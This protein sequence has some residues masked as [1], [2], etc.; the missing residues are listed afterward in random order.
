MATTTNTNVDAALR[1]L[2]LVCSGDAGP[3]VDDVIHPEFVNHRAAAVRGGPEGFRD[4][5]RWLGAA[6][7]DISI[8]PQDVITSGDK[9]VAR[10]RFRALHVGPFNGI[11]ATNRTI[12]L[13]QLHIWR[14]E[15][16][17]IA[18]HWGSMDELSGLN[19]MGVD[20]PK[21]RHDS[22]DHSAR[23]E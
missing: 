10:T 22:Y 4:L 20:L 1:S 6:F 8:T 7:A 5:I 11:P 15:D 13:D 16:G 21:A 9:V 12:A 19:E 3:A 14:I 17:L 23:V 18:E 2:E